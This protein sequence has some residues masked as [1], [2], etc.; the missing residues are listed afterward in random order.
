MKI[1]KTKFILSVFCAVLV[2]L[3]GTFT[4]LF[5]N[6]GI[7]VFNPEQYESTGD[8][9]LTKELNK[10]AV[11]EDVEDLINIVEN[12]HPIFLEG[13]NEKY[14][15][16]KDLLLQETNKEMK[17]F[18]LQLAVSKYLSSIQDGHTRI[19]WTED[20]FLNVNWIYYDNKLF[21]LNDDN[22]ITGNEVTKINNVKIE[23]IISKISELFPAEN[24]SAEVLNVSNYS[25]S[26]LL[27][28]YAGVNA[29]DKVTL[30]LSS[31]SGENTLD[32][33]FINLSNMDR[34][35]FEIS[36]KQINDK[37]FYLNLGFCEINPA[38]ESVVKDLKSAIASGTS[39]VIIDLRNN[40]GGD[41][42]A[43]SKI[44]KAM[45]MKPG[46]YG[47]I[48]RFSPL[49]QKYRGYLRKSGYIK[50]EG[51]NT[52][53]KNAAINLYVITNESTFSSATMLA[54][55]VRDGNLGTIVGR[56]SSNMPSSYGDIL[57]FQLENSKLEG[58]ISF[59]KWIRPDATKANERSLEPDVYVNYWEDPLEEVLEL[60]N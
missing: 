44:L 34:P 42:T 6:Q 4:Y 3:A 5:F 2:I 37:T 55:W 53:V 28:N 9:Q 46:S 51:E 13:E 35:D 59:K 20:E 27:L 7:S 39:N 31:E 57:P 52:S 29:S 38:L 49:A 15:K 11:K 1:N 23:T 19:R 54:T 32:V 50:I 26:K 41:S 33:N 45:D 17:V 18:E 22:I 47:V 58:I 14:N 16:A 24:Y 30:T 10:V 48:I 12:T 56:A 43:C 60:I 40:P 25:K 8:V 36:S 21:L